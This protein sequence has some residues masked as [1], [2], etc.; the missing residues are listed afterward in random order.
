M[1]GD[2]LI[3]GGGAAERRASVPQSVPESCAPQATWLGT[4]GEVRPD[5]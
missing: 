5:R 4:F 2:V 3:A 1:E